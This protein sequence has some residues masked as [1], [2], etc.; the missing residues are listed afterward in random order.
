MYCFCK[1]SGHRGIKNKVFLRKYND[2]NDFSR[3]TQK[4]IAETTVFIRF[5]PFS[6][7]C[8][9]LRNL[10]KTVVSAIFFVFFWKKSL[11]SLYFLRKT[12]FFDGQKAQNLTKT[13]VSAIFFCVFCLFCV[14][15]VFWLFSRAPPRKSAGSEGDAPKKR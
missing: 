11:K 13:M 10:T 4:N 5:Y 15:C 3:K 1:V 6:G 2:F 14:F 7:P 9:N 8:Q 12:W